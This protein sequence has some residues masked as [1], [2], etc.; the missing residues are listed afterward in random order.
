MDIKKE[1]I[2]KMATEYAKQFDYAEDSSS[3]LDYIAG[4]EK[5]LSL[6]AVSSSTLPK[7]F[8]VYVCTDCGEINVK[9]DNREIRV[10]FC[11]ECDYP[12]WNDDVE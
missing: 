7:G 12:L 4:F 3:F 6:F 5:A 10:G 2:E 1:Q 9:K 11:D 8:K